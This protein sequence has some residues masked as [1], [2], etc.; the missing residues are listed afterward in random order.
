MSKRALLFPGQGSQYQGMGKELYD[1]FKI[2]KETYE[3]ACDALKFDIAKL[4]FEGPEDEL[5]LTQ[6][7][8]PAILTHSIAAL[9]VISEESDIFNDQ[10]NLITAGHSLGEFSALVA[11]GSLSFFEAVQTVAKRGEFMQ[12]ACEPGLGTMA[13]I[14]AVKSEEVRKVCEAINTD[15]YVV[16]PANFNSELQTVIS[17]H[18]KAVLEASEKLK[19]MEAKVFPLSVSAPFHS[20]LMGPAAEKLATQLSQIHVQ[21]S[22]FPYIANVTAEVNDQNTKPATITDLLVKQMYSPVRWLQTM[23]T[24]NRENVE[25]VIEFGPG[26][27]LCGLMKRF[28]RKLPFKFIDKVDH[29]KKFLGKE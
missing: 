12:N 20:P 28:N 13:A 8:Q 19:E 3:E 11:N 21:N 4:S 26:K 29:V 27:V 1:N 6:N 24:I 23:E 17:G 22:Y 9:K 18:T 15:D 25:M 10:D 2:A 7:T 14:T 5:K 16:V